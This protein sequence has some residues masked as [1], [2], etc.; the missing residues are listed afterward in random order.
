MM[1]AVG[2]ILSVFCPEEL[3]EEIEG[4]LL[5]RYRKDVVKYGG[6]KAKRRLLWNTI[7]FFRPSIILRNK[8]SIK[9]TYMIRNYVKI[10]F[11]NILKQKSYTI[12][13][14]LGLSLGMAASLLI[15]QYVK[16]E[17]SF[18]TFHNRAEDI[19]RIQ[20]NGYHNGELNFESA[21][22]VPAI[23]TFLKKNFPEVEATARLFPRSGVM[24]YQNAN[25]DLISFHETKMQYAA[26]EF[27][28]MFNFPL[29]AGD[30]ATCLQGPYK[31]AISKRASKKYFG[32]EDA[33]GKRMTLGSNATFDVTA[34]FEDV[35]ENS[36][37]RFDFLFSYATMNAWTKDESETAWGWYDF[38]S[39]VRLKPG[40]DVAALQAK[41][42]A[43][44]QK[45]RGEEWRKENA[46]Q[47]FILRPLLDIH[48]KSHLL[49]EAQPDDQRDSDG[50]YALSVIAFFILAIAWI[51]YINLATA[52]SLN[53]ANEVGV[54][55][56]MGAFRSQ[57]IYQFL[58]ES[59]IMNVIGCL[60]ALI[61][62]RLS[63]HSFSDLSGWHIPLAF[64][65]ESDFWIMVVGLF[66][67]GTV[68][69][70]FYPAI[71]LSSFRPAAVL[72]GK[73]MKS[74]G[75][76][77][78]RKSLVMFQFGASVFLIVGSIVVYNQL[79]FMKNQDLGVSLGQTM[80]FKGPG[81]TDSLF[82][83]KYESFKNE[84]IRIPGI[85]SITSSSTIPGDEIYWTSNIRLLTA[86]S[87][88]NIVVSGGLIDPDY[89]TSYGIKVLAGRNFDR[90]FNDRGKLLLNEALS[91][92]LAFRQPQDAVGKNVI[93]GRDTFEVVGVLED[94]H[95]MSLKSPVAPLAILMGN[96]SR[97][98]SMKVET[99]N[100]HGVVDAVAKPWNTFFPGN[101]IDYFFLDQFYN[102]QYEKDDRFGQVFTLF[103]FMAIFIASLGLF[104]LASFMALQRTKEIGI[105]KVLGSSVSGIV[106]LLAKGFLQPV[107]IANLIAW[108]LAWWVMDRWLQTFPYHISVNPLFFIVAGL[109]VVVIAFV[110]V[111]SQTLKAAMTRPAE[112][113]KYE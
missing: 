50:V 41:I 109:A 44:L 112:T 65:Y 31:L 7:R 105:R 77:I 22:A 26:P 10:A 43:Q 19:Y 74:S 5:Q 89:V 4:D 82:N 94:Y 103:T 39:F 86:P 92:T 85:K 71:V 102:R 51:N 59:F 1:K 108:P 35:P 60:L 81:V 52:R 110:S 49:Y 30:R 111:S 78:L 23:T 11:R 79:R 28:E 88:Q 72:K 38:Y 56:V 32:D 106:M 99:E 13:N 53:R 113:L 12:L 48:L 2:K 66:A 84:V 9:R 87:T 27:L 45:E 15:L 54:R 55:K 69:S 6:K 47:E 62:V 37:V 42:D 100:Y 93:F 101:P 96:S 80:V 29:L 107:V 17:K 90:Q 25:G 16:Y 8:I 91:K 97:F 20:Y 63:W 14:V 57:L 70:G 33:I 3:R 104:G 34:V 64:I 61:L 21:V 98:F 76:N 95:Q 75:G 18:D 36:H 68:L 67:M 24:S 46:S 58:T 83:S 73:L 40:T